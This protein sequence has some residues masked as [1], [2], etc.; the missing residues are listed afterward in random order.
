MAHEVLPYSQELEI[1]NSCTVK[2]A[3]TRVS[4][5][6]GL[7]RQEW[8]RMSSR[9]HR[10][11]QDLQE[12]NRGQV[13]SPQPSSRLTS[14]CFWRKG[15]CMSPTRRKVLHGEMAQWEPFEAETFS[16]VLKPSSLSCSWSCKS[17]TKKNEKSGAHAL[18][19]L[20]QWQMEWQFWNLGFF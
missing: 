4:P 20:L 16:S 15:S 17:A 5:F 14:S 8:L 9:D 11:G 2:V 3:K 1:V 6:P 12:I 7:Y 10:S 13:Q 19:P 18:I